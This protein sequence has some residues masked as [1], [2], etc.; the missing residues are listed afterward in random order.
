MINDES[1]LD[2]FP[3]ALPVYFGGTVEMQVEPNVNAAIAGEMTSYFYLDTR[4]IGAIDPTIDD[5]QPV[6]QISESS[7]AT[8]ADAEFIK[9][10]VITNMQP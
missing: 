1:I 4:G 7:S 8:E 9:N 10:S 2:I 3:G 5:L 6:F